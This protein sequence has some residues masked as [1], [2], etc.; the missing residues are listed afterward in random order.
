MDT[1]DLRSLIA[2][3]RER[4]ISKAAAS[5][6]VTQSTL[7]SRVHKLEE[8]L[9][10]RMFERSWEG[11][12]LTVEGQFFVDSA[13]QTLNE[14]LDMTQFLHARKERGYEHLDEMTNGSRLHIGINPFVL[15]FIGKPLFRILARDYPDA[16]CRISSDRTM[17][18]IDSIDSGNLHLGFTTFR[19]ERPNVGFRALREDTCI[20]LYPA[21]LGWS[22]EEIHL[23]ADEL[24][25]MPFLMLDHPD[26]VN[27]RAETKQLFQHIL[28]TPP[29]RAHLVDDLHVLMEM[30]SA[31]CGYGSIA[32][33]QV[34]ELLPQYP[35]VRTAELMA[36]SPTFTI[37]LAYSTRRAS[38]PI[39]EL[40][41]K[42]TAS[43]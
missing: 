24:Q 5:L 28:G 37:Y 26:I 36:D 4:S 38:F 33:M 19:E 14:L 34:Q 2:I 27:F 7:S 32:R 30:I 29:K 18:L 15:S 23:R 22:P 35:M 21:G 12:A 6:H 1:E 41:D 10:L 20:L 43:F 8:S 16:D 39:L 17:A 3:A 13:L 11:T 9:G 42:I 40:A 31:G 25:A